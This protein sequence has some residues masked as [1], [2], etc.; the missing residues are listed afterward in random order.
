MTKTIIN[1]PEYDLAFVEGDMPI[2]LN[3]FLNEDQKFDIALTIAHD[4]N[5]ANHIAS[6]SGQVIYTARMISL[7]SR[8]KILLDLNKMNVDKKLEAD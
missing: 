1:I 8:L 3:I 7:F 6:Q 2:Y 4:E 5:E